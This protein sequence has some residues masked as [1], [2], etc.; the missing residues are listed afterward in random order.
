[1]IVPLLTTAAE[2][3]DP[4]LNVLKPVNVFAAPNCA[5]EE[6]AVPPNEEVFVAVPVTFPVS[7]PLNPVADVCKPLNMFAP[8]DAPVTAPVL[9]LKEIT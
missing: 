6:A 5:H 4:L 1:M 9:P 3:P 7:G 2:I 8:S